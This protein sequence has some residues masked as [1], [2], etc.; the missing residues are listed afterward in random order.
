MA[1]A[2]S[3]IT[4]ISPYQ[5]EPERGT[6]HEA[7]S[8]S[9]SSSS[10]DENAEIDDEFENKNRWRNSTLSWCHCGQCSIMEKT[11][12]NFCCHEK[13]VEYD[14]YDAK[15][16]QAEVSNCTCV[17]QLDEFEQNML[18]ESVLKIDACRYV[19]ENWPL[20]DDELER[21]HKIFRLVAYLRCS[22]WIFEYLGKK[23]R[24][25]FP[26]CIYSS[27]RKRF[28]SPDGIYSGFKYPKVKAK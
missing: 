17:T 1:M 27:I 9:D 5:F 16:V 4:E 3:T 22:R 15:L 24:R 2:N 18:N 20:G 21:T 6:T 14:E 12:E 26:A 10:D 23:N 13:A 25:P 8:S 28:A 7:D 19:E 11:I